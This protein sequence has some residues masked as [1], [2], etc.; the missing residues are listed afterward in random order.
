MVVV[1]A[2]LPRSAMCPRLEGCSFYSRRPHEVQ[3]LATNFV[4][5]VYPDAR[6]L[7]TYSGVPIGL[8]CAYHEQHAGRSHFFSDRLF[9]ARREAFGLA[10]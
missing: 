2:S 9:Q 1:T 8:M 6:N 3:H 4:I 5:Y 10:R 7:G